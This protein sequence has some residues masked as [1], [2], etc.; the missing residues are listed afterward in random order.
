MMGKLVFAQN[1]LEV[2][3]RNIE[4]NAGKFTGLTFYSPHSLSVHFPDV[5]KALLNVFQD[6][7]KNHGKIMEY[8][9]M[10]VDLK[11]LYTP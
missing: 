2:D 4:I 9:I 3:V 5:Y 6:Y 11:L 7:L 10:E 1:L 8:I